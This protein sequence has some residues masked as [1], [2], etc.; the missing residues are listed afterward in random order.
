[1]DRKLK[2]P[3]ITIGR[4]YCAYG[5]TVAAALA[6]E[7]GIKYYDKDFLNKTVDESGFSEDV[8]R[9]ESETMSSGSKI[10]EDV[11]GATA[12][13]SSSYD[14]IFEAQKEVALEL[15]KSPCIIVGRCANNILKEAGIGSFNIYLYAGLDCRIRRCAELNPEIEEKDLEKYVKKMDSDRQ[16]YYKRYAGSEVYDPHNYNICL[17]VGTLGPEAAVEVILSLVTE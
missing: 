15:A 5:R 1:M 12:V 6:K 17:D 16:I 14:R 3:V 7:L 9:E 4:E 13:Y 10:L 11:L 2:Y 8:V